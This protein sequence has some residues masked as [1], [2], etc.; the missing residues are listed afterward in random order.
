[1]VRVPPSRACYNSGIMLPL[2]P[3][4][5]TLSLSLAGLHAS[6]VEGPWSLGVRSAIGWAGGVG[7]RA[8]QLDAA[9][10]EIRPRDLDRS[11]RR[12]LAAAIRRASLGFTGLD[13]WIPKAHFEPGEHADRAHAAL[14]AGVTLAADLRSLAASEHRAATIVAVTLPEDYEGR[15]EVRAHADGLA[16]AIEDHAAATLS[17][18]E[19]GTDTASAEHDNTSAH[20]AIR[21]GVDTGRVILRGDPPGKTFAR[22]S[23]SLASLRLNDA[24]DT[25]RREMGRGTLGIDTLLAL[26]TTL[27]PDLPIVTDLRGLDNPGRAATAAHERLGGGADL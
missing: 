18:A 17:H 19:T 25:G 8:V 11:G 4:H 27:T 2:P 9:A 24:D 22:L 3:Q 12:D 7:F 15:D 21:P 23:K 20:D 13:L 5:R 1:M 16:V 6:A 26:H 14:L 10:P